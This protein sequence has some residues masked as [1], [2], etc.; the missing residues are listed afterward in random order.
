[1]LLG[2]NSTGVKVRWGLQEGESYKASV[3]GVQLGNKLMQFCYAPQLQHRVKSCMQG[4]GSTDLCLL[5]RAGH[6]W[7]GRSPCSAAST[8]QAARGC[9][10][11]Q[12]TLRGLPVTCNYQDDFPCRLADRVHQYT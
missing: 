5:C 4:A 10:M 7:M 2:E 6:V 11:A 3:L 12:L 9:S 1:M 8:R